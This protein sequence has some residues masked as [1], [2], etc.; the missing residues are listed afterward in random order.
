MA[1]A[2]SL[3][4]AYQSGTI[5]PDGGFIITGFFADNTNYAIYEVTAYQNVK[6]IYQVPEGLIF[7]TDGNRTH[8]LVEPPSY[9]QKH[10]EPVNRNTGQTI[11]Y[12]FNE[13]Q[14]AKMKNQTTVMI[15]MEPIMLFASF[16]ILKSM[17]ES[18]SFVF[19]PTP[20]V[21]MAIKKFLSDSLYNDCRFGKTEAAESTATILATIKKFSIWGA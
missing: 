6:D 11:P 4:K 17:G 10:I 12:R 16:T 13:L 18:F 15:P 14:I 1:K 2:L 9:S 8:M 5:P 20:D 21:Y 7:K 19:Y 3:L